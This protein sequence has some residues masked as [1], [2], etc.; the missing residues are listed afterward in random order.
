MVEYTQKP[1]YNID[2]LIDIVRLLRSEGG[3]PWDREQTHESIR[4]DFIEETCEAIEAIDLKDT[5]LLR[6]EL[7]DVLLQVVFHCRI[8]YAHQRRKIPACSHESTEGG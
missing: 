7:G 3:C 1:E 4:N 8:R 2:D 6:E 5:E